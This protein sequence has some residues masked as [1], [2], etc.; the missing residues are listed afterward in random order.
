MS[1]IRDF[2]LI[3]NQLSTNILSLRNGSVRNQILVE[4]ENNPDILTV[5]KGLNRIMFSRDL[6]DKSIDYGNF[7]LL[8]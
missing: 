1:P 8:P 2:I 7:S 6:I 5:P 3:H 4:I